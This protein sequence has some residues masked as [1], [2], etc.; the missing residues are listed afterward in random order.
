MIFIRL[1]CRVL[2]SLSNGFCD[3]CK[4][5]I[6]LIAKQGGGDILRAYGLVDRRI[7]LVSPEIGL[8]PRGVFPAWN[9][10]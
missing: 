4:M 9:Y 2:L 6:F 8:A 5:V 3:E 7:V 10:S 1:L